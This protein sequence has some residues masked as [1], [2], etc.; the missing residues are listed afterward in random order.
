MTEPELILRDFV[1]EDETLRELVANRIYPLR[2]PP[3]STLPAMTFFLV[4]T[5]PIGSSPDTGTCYWSRIQITLWSKG[6]EQLKTVRTALKAHI[7]SDSRY[8]WLV[9]SDTYEDESELFSQPI[10]ILF[11]H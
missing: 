4:S 11:S 10:D 1:L 6:Y 7:K 5:T 3:D 9:Q 2:L 8:S